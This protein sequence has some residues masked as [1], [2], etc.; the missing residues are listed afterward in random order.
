MNPVMHEPYFGKQESQESIQE[1]RN[2]AKNLH[3]DFRI[4][5]VDENSV[6]DPF[7]IDWYKHNPG[8][9]AGVIIAYS[10]SYL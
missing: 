1:S 7:V 9:D 10:C 4:S 2:Q 3:E 8:S 5:Y 6:S